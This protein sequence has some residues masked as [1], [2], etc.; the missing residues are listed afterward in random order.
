LIAA[1]FDESFDGSRKKV[2]VAGGFL[3]RNSSWFHLEHRWNQLLQKYEL[4][5]YR[6][7]DCEHGRG[8]FEKFRTHHTGHLLLEDRQKLSL[9]RL[10]FID[11]ILAGK[12]IAGFAVGIDLRAFADVC[13]SE[14]KLQA[15]GGTPFYYGYH[16]AMLSAAREVNRFYGGMIAF[17][18]D[19]HEEYSGLMLRTHD[20]LKNANPELRHTLGRVMFEDKKQYIGLQVADLFIY[21]VKRSLEV[22]LDQS[23]HG[24]R[25][26]MAR[27][28]EGPVVAKID[29]CSN[30][31]LEKYLRDKGLL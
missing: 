21:E 8:A 11:A 2:F 6:A 28:K 22:R 10:E 1:Y 27:L 30:A 26:E 16:L 25:E 4:P 19:R 15:F 29:I 23:G 20:N 17:V 9:I 7:V 31:C 24:E 3:G 12:D 18:G 13:D 14:S 5:Y